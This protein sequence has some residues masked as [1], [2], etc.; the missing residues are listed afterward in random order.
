MTDDLGDMNL[1][2]DGAMT[3]AGSDVRPAARTYLESEFTHDKG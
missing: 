3:T 2:G 1:F